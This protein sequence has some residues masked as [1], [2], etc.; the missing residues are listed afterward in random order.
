MEDCT[1][2]SLKYDIL[3]KQKWK[4]YF[5][6]SCIEKKPYVKALDEYQKIFIE[7]D[8]SFKK[9]NENNKLKNVLKNNNTLFE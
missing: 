6:S 2:L 8:I 1:K 7:K 4:E 3:L 9:C 5:E